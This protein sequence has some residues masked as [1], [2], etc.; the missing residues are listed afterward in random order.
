MRPSEGDDCGVCQGT[1][2][3]AKKAK[4]KHTLVILPVSVEKLSPAEM[5]ERM[6]R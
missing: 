6:L 4:E 2:L 5:A 1:A 3:V